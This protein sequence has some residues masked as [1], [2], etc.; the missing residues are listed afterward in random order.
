MDGLHFN[1]YGKVEFTRIFADEL[2]K[3]IEDNR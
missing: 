1:E 3:V 2:I